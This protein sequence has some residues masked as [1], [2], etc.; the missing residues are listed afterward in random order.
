[1][2]LGKDFNK[3]LLDEQ[4]SEVSAQDSELD[5]QVFVELA[6]KF[7]GAADRELKRLYSQL[8]DGLKKSEK[9]ALEKEI[10]AEW[11]DKLKPFLVQNN[12]HF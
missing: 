4:I 2:K 12:S 11:T 9:E 1:M 5:A 6:S 8:Q 10:L 7:F 3:D